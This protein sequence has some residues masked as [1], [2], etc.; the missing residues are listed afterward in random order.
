LNRSARFP[1]AR[2][3]A[4]APLAAGWGVSIVSIQGNA[5]VKNRKCISMI[6]IFEN[7]NQDIKE[8][9][10]ANVDIADNCWN[11]TASRNQYGYGRMCITT[12]YKKKKWLQAHR[13]SY[14]IFYGPIPEGKIICHHCDNPACV[15][16][17]H[18]Y[19]GTW[20]NN[21]H[22]AV[23]RGNMNVGVKNGNSR[24]TEVDIIDI[25]NKYSTG[26]FTYRQIA[27]EYNTYPMTICDIVR[28]KRWKHVV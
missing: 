25:R 10:W 26:K 12:S 7:L 19:C 3:T 4:S 13:I 27:N 24:F 8:R 1:R 9:F 22:D 23:V 18:L 16:P 15:R 6:K 21:T 5:N 28:R 17:D 20:A 11:W 14:A 2:A